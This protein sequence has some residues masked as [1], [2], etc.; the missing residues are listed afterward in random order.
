MNR[1]THEELADLRSR[2]PNGSR[3]KLTCMNDPY[4]QDLKPGMLGTVMHVDDIGTIHVA[5]D[6]GSTLDA[7]GLFTQNRKT[8]GLVSLCAHVYFLEI[9]NCA[10]AETDTIRYD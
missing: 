9:F 10:F 3:V 4:C 2:Y 6:C 1:L 7:S 8:N 5:W